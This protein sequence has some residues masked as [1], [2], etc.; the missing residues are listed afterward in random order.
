[1]RKKKVMKS[2]E[3][4]KNYLE[5]YTRT[6]HFIE[7]VLK[8]RKKVGI[9]EGG[10]A[11]P[12]P[13]KKELIFNT[14]TPVTI[15]G[16]NYNGIK[17]PTY[18]SEMD[19]TY[20][21]LI[22]PL[23]KI[24]SN[25]GLIWF[26]NFFILYNVRD[27]DR[28]SMYL[29]YHEQTTTALIYSRF[30][31]LE[32][33]GC[34][35]CSVKVSEDYINTVSEKYPISIGISPYATQNEVIDLVKKSWELMQHEFRELERNGHI[36]EFKDEKKWLSKIR[37]RCE[38]SLQIEDIVYENRHLSLADLVKKIKEETGHVF[39][40]GEIG[41]IRSLAKKRRENKK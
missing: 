21:E 26:I 17:Y 40:Q 23:P 27:Y 3:K 20:R 35:D 25:I 15:L 12:P 6:D 33:M 41:K 31:Y 10:I 39:D 5:T 37:K 28:L 4:L 18:P 32:R 29:S 30:D 8:I 1:M 38:S 9:P 19:Q 13:S 22:E 34:C 11:T 7:R 14:N 2:L 24:Y 36:P 16:I